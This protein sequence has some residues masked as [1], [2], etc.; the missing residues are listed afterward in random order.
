VDWPEVLLF[1]GAVPQEFTGLLKRCADVRRERLP[2]HWARSGLFRG[3]PM[4]AI[5]NGA[6]PKR[7]YA[8]VAGPDL[9][10]VCNIG[11]CGALDPAMRVA[12]IFVATQ[13]NGEPVSRPRSSNASFAGPLASIDHVA[14][15]AAEKSGLHSAGAMAVEMEAAGALKRAQALNVPFYS[16][17]VVSDL[18]GETLHCD[19]NRALRDDGRVGM[20]RLAAE[21]VMGPFTCL[22]ELLRLARRAALAS[23]RLGEFLASC[24]F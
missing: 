22:P 2:V 23:E 18:A 17:R 11:F 13:V 24:E 7:A 12:D 10:A 3:R 16:V 1:V 20:A 15:T 6:G 5:A 4:V 8:A 14:R 19:F 21:A 9:Q